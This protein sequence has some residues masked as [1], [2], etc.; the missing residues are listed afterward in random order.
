MSLQN[1]LNAANEEHMPVSAK[2]IRQSINDGTYYDYCNIFF[3]KPQ[4][5]DSLFSKI[6]DIRLIEEQDGTGVSVVCDGGIEYRFA[7]HDDNIS[8]YD[9]PEK[10]MQ[11]ITEYDEQHTPD[12]TLQY[13]ATCGVPYYGYPSKV[14]DYIRN[15]EDRCE[16]VSITIGKD[17]AFDQYRQGRELHYFVRNVYLP[18]AI[19]EKMASDA[20][21][22]KRYEASIKKLELCPN[23]EDGDTK[24]IICTVVGLQILENGDENFWHDEWRYP[25]GRHVT[26]EFLLPP[27][28]E[29][30][31]DLYLV[32]REKELQPLLFAK[33]NGTY[34]QEVHSKN[35]GFAD[36]QGKVSFF[37]MVDDPDQC[38]MGY[39]NCEPW[40]PYILLH[41]SGEQGDIYR[42]VLNDMFLD[43]YIGLKCGDKMW[44]TRFH[45]KLS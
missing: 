25:G 3:N 18:Y 27:A 6:Y 10:L 14:F 29:E 44:K 9:T 41:K 32:D 4:K 37:M 43:N 40:Q 22:A 45:D 35:P 20:S 21:V 31:V 30:S 15:L 8:S 12:D 17:K 2:L 23:R 16:N 1:F 19:A 5:K 33:L 7:V 39:M 36:A 28:G 11:A 38:M 13:A 34:M 24:Y 42:L 26:V